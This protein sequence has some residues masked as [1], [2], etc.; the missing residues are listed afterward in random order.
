MWSG[1]CFFSHYLANL[2]SYY[3]AMGPLSIVVR[4]PSQ[5]QYASTMFSALSHGAAATGHVTWVCVYVNLP[6]L[7]KAVSKSTA[8]SRIAL[9]M[10]IVQMV[11]EII[12]YS[13]KF[14]R[15]SIFMDR[16]CSNTL[17]FKFR[18]CTPSTNIIKY[19]AYTNM[20]ILWV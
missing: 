10:V 17:Q 12:L 13:W 20:F 1:S 8:A 19:Y 14:S 18:R 16:Q 3:A 6:G 11:S 15:G 9:T 7:V 2:C 5:L 4:D